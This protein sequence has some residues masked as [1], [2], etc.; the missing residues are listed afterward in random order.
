M[1]LMAAWMFRSHPATAAGTT[2]VCP[3]PPGN[4][5]Q[6]FFQVD[7]TTG[8]VTSAIPLKGLNV[9]GADYDGVECRGAGAGKC[10]LAADFAGFSLLNLQVFN[11]DPAAN[12]TTIGKPPNV[13]VVGLAW[14]S[15]NSTLYTISDA[16]QLYKVDTSNGALTAVGPGGLDITGNH[17]AAMAYDAA[18]KK[19]YLSQ[20]T[21]NPNPYKLT[22]VDPLTG[23]QDPTYGPVTL[24][25]D[26]AGGVT[27]NEVL[28][29]T[30]VGGTLYAS[31]SDVNDAH[32]NLATINPTTGA[33]TDIGPHGVDY[34]GAITADAGGTL[35][36]IAGTRGANITPL[37]CPSSPTPSPS[38][39]TPGPSPSSPT[40]SPSVTPPGPTPSPSVSVGPATFTRTPTPG[41]SVLGV[42]QSRRILP[43]TGSNA[44][45]LLLFAGMCYAFG[46]VA[47][48]VASRRRGVAVQ[49][50]EDSSE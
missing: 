31:L 29:L 11:C 6:A 33:V 24:G 10:F 16:G 46:A 45:P 13:I 41:T 30:F 26:N 9:E 44:L 3:T 48:K 8:K 19:I 35:Y 7:K 15:D 36:A 32:P 22:R 4:P 28:G 2:P 37:P 5:C 27:R 49:P 12:E 38:P 1:L 47:L 18:T 43:V 17:I 34:I 23:I 21:G 40:P 25:T 14:D 39:S 42:S 50:E 20:D